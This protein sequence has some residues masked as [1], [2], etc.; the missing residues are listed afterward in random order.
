MKFIADVNIA[1][2]VI[3]S[4]RND[5]HD[6]VDIKKLNLQA[7]DIQI[8]NLALKENRII[9][10]HDKDFLALVKFPQY[11]VGI[12][13]IRLL[14]QNAPHHCEKLKKLLEEDKEADLTDSLT[15]VREDIVEHYRYKGKK[16]N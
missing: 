14:Q 11:Q 15:I 7:S 2:F 4:L 3:K 6:V 1:Q 10:T 8:I 9:L 12:I 13:L 5:R 16:I